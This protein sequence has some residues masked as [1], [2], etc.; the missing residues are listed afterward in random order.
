M[1]DNSHLWEDGTLGCSEEHVK[2]CS[3]EDQKCLN[4]SLGLTEVSF[5]IPNEVYNKIVQESVQKGINI[6]YLL[7]QTIINSIE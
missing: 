3:P 6:Q 2:V 5:L 7:R 4:E 1:K